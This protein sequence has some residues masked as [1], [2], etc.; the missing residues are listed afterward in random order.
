[1]TR[2]VLAQ[3]GDSY[4]IA[5]ARL[6]EE[7]LKGGGITN[8][9]VLDAIGSTPRHEFVAAEHRPQAYFDKALPIGSSQTIS[10]PYI[11]AV[12]TQE[13]D[14]QPNEKVLEI[15]TGSGYQAAVLSRLV[16]DVYS[17][18]IVK[19]LGEH[20]AQVLQRLNY[21]NVHTKIGD[22][23]QGWPEFAPFDKIIVTC[24]PEDVPQPLIDQLA[25]GGLM[26]I[27]VGERY[28]QTLMMM[29]KR[30]KELERE[31]LR[32]T[33]F[34]PMTG[35]AEDKRKVQ[36]DPANPTLINGDFEEQPL[37]SGDVPG[38]YYQ[39]GLTWNT[40]RKSPSGNHYIS[41]TNDS[42]GS[43]TTL[44]QGFAIDGKLVPRLRVSATVK[45]DNVSVGQV[46]DELPAVTV[47]FFDAK[48]ERLAIQWLGPYRG[49][50]RW[51][52]DRR[53][54]RVPEG[55]KEAI[56]SLGLFGGVGTVAFDNVTIEA[57]K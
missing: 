49:T 28:Q 5:R 10:S 29:R 51:H 2:I 18:E 57:L 42:P 31:A 30:G 55:T 11:V 19:E 13:L 47:Q 23:F 15:G 48:R 14:P 4:A 26:I 37:K 56:V 39:R 40:D 17:I 38:W 50:L 32:P 21:K 8:Q 12:M 1:M 25:D 16:K 44:L 53:V 33:L 46:R 34:V 27:P 6:V 54:F 43:P 24:S 45:S 52:T 36:A 20:A 3:A 7:V 22:G 41:F 9:R 35:A